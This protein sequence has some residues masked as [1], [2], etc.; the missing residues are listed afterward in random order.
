MSFLYKP[1]KIKQC[2]NIPY[3]YNCYK[4]Y[5]NYIKYRHNTIK[6]NNTLRKYLYNLYQTMQFTHNYWSIQSH[7]TTNH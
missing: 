1:C 6:I 7:P 3:E 4:A 2:D 5:Y